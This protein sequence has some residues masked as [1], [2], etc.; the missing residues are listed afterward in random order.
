MAGR[1]RQEETKG[2]RLNKSRWIRSQPTSLSAREVVDKA[3]AEGIALTLS[4]VYTARST[5]KS[6]ATTRGPSPASPASEG[7]AKRGK[8]DLRHQFAVLAIRLGTDEAQ[9][10]LD[11][12]VA[13]RTG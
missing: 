13:R 7:V 8:G 10:V 1:S 2:G 9:H 5:V 3:R 11:E 6:A 4:Q 12:L